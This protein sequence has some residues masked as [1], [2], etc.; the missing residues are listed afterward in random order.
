MDLL[1]T[2][3]SFSINV[4]DI[5]EKKIGNQISYSEQLAYLHL[6]K[7]I[8]F[9]IGIHERN[10]YIMDSPEAARG[11]L[12]SL[13]LHLLHPDRSSCEIAQNILNSVA[14]RPPLCWSKSFHTALARELLGEE[15]ADGLKLD[16]TNILTKGFLFLFLTLLRFLTW[17][18]PQTEESVARKRRL[19]RIVLNKQMISTRETTKSLPMESCCPFGKI[20]EKTN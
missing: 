8:G 5:I 2:L 12:E 16:K 9:L 14:G 1:V 19:M 7:Y 17:A 10:L 3:L 6:W 13:V 11:A 4:I 18:L 15:L 20:L